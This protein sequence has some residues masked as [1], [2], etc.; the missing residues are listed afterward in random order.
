[1]KPGS[2]PLRVPSRPVCQFSN[3]IR[4][5]PLSRRTFLTASALKT[6]TAPRQTTRTP[7]ARPWISTR[8]VQTSW[9]DVDQ[10]DFPPETAV[11]PQSTSDSVAT[12]KTQLTHV[13]A[14]IKA[15]FDSNSVESEKTIFEVLEGMV[16]IAQS[17]IAIRAR[18][19]RPTKTT[20]RQSSAGAILSGLNSEDTPKQ[21]RT[22]TKPLGL[23]ELPT[24]VYLSKLAEGLLKH[25]TVFIGPNVLRI[26]IHLQRLLNRAHAIPEILYLYANKPVP[27]EGSSPPKFSNPSPKAAS[28]A[29]PADLA[30]Q[31]LTAAIEAKDMPL[32]LSVIDH[33]Y[34]A[35][36]WIRHR[37]LTKMGIPS[38][39]AAMTPLAI[40]MIA[41]E[42]SV[43]SGYIDPWL[44]KLYTFAGLS[45]YVLCTG[46]LGF[47]ALTTYNDDH[48][49]VVWRPGVPLLDRYV[50]ADERAAL[51]RIAC[52]WGFKEL[53]KRGDEEGEEWE[54]LRQLCLW[55]GMVLDKSDLLPGMNP[56]R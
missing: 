17:A 27:Q 50:R 54:G 18:Q 4:Q 44:F 3:Y 29:I 36:A 11:S 46:T 22:Y 25:P 38:I 23:N 51:D 40:Y 28:Q 35:P 41:Q 20:V 15:I 39:L 49:R 14:Q 32:A 43:Y 6:P 52:A 24:P 48:D 55:R 26:Y 13:E 1:M 12:V 53:W 30:E 45:T 8:H 31:S 34:R 10:E 21:K 16:E 9:R 33:T 2:L 7:P 37:K 5:Q 56:G 47:V 42:V 19:P